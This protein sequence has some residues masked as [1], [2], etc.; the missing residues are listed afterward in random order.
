MIKSQKANNDYPPPGLKRVQ[1]VDSP[2][3]S[4]FL[5]YTPPV[6]CFLSPRPRFYTSTPATQTQTGHD[7]FIILKTPVSWH[8]QG[9]RRQRE[10]A[11]RMSLDRRSLD[12]TRAD[13]RALDKLL[14]E[15]NFIIS[16][17][18]IKCCQYL[19]DDSPV[20]VG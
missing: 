15:Y 5:T 9:G 13:E 10:E 11:D 3:D 14:G 8:H 16:C 7:D 17:L 1:A 6:D 12:R 19:E 20:K 4:L 2:I 18:Q